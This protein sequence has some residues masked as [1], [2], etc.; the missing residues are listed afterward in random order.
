MSK[1]KKSMEVSV[2]AY[3]SMESSVVTLSSM[4]P[5]GVTTCMDSVLLQGDRI[6]YVNINVTPFIHIKRNGSFCIEF[7]GARSS[8]I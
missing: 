5:Y 7:N 8:N 6:L 3:N 2:I 4:E 1:C